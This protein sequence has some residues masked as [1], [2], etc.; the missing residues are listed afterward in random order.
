MLYLQ[1]YRCVHMVLTQT[2]L[3]PKVGYTLASPTF[4]TL[5]S[6]HELVVGMSVF[7]G[8]PPQH[9][10]QLETLKDRLQAYVPTGL[11]HQQVRECSSTSR[12]VR[13]PVDQ[14]PYLFRKRVQ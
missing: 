8:E 7:R 6:A 14:R 1:I 4:E 10:D 12:L 11:V 2:T 5:S 9:S 3:A 13:K